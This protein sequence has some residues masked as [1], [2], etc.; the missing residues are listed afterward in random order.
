MEEENVVK[1]SV[2]KPFVIKNSKMVGEF[3]ARANQPIR[4]TPG[5]PHPAVAR[6]RLWW[7]ITEVWELAVAMWRHDLVE[8]ADA[9]V[10]IL[11]FTYGIGHNYGIDID[12]CF[13]EVHRSNMTKDFTQFY[14]G[15]ER[16]PKV[17]KG[18][19][20]EPPNLR[21]VIGL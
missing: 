4:T 15:D 19:N 3:L 14:E 13:R 5:F 2:R 9:A 10:D 8:I 17:T 7:I 1:K 6:R 20:Y 18:K 21:K 16:I 11:Y 12:A